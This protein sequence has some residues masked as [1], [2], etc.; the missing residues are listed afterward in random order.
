MSRRVTIAVTL[1]LIAICGLALVPGVQATDVT[2]TDRPDDV[3][4][5][6]E[7]NDGEQITKETEMTVENND[8][9]NSADVDITSTP[10]GVSVDASP[11][12]IGPGET[13]EVD[14]DVTADY[15]AN[16]GTVEGTVGD[17]AFE[18]EVDVTQP[19]QPG[20]EDEPLDLGDVL[21]GETESGDVTVEEIGGDQRLNGVSWE[22]DSDDSDGDLSFSGMSGFDGVEGHEGEAEWT[23]T[24][25]DDADQHED[26]EWTVELHDDDHDYATREVDVEARVIYPGQFGEMDHSGDIVFDEPR[27]ETTT[28]TQDIAL[29]IPNEGDLELDVSS[30]TAS[31]SEPGIS[32]SVFNSPTEIDGRSSET[33]TLRVEADTDLE[34]GQ[35]DIS[36]TASA[37]DFDV[38]DE[39]YTGS[40]WIEHEI[41]LSFA[42]SSIDIGDVPIGEPESV[43]TELE[44]T[45][46]YDDV[47]NLEV[48][49]EDGPDSWMIFE[50]ASDS[51]GAGESEELV[52]DLEF[53][54]S[55]SQGTD[56]EWVYVADGFGVDSDSITV[57]ATPVPLDLDPIRADITAF[58]DAGETEA[59]IATDA[60]DVIDAMDEQ[61]RAG[62]AADD[63]ISRTLAFGDATSLYL[64]AFGDASA[65]IDAG[66]HDAAQT[67]LARAAVA[68]NMMVVYTEN[69]ESQDLQTA[70]EDV[71]EDAGGKL[72][73]MIDDQE[74]YYETQ[75]EEG[76]ESLREEATIQRELAQI[77]S[78]Q[79]D[80]ERAE[81]LDEAADEAFEAY[82]EAVADGES[83]RQRA[84]EAWEEMDD[85]LFVSVLGEPL[86]VNPAH[87]DAF[88]DGTA[89]VDEAYGNAVASLEAAGEANRAET[90]ANEHDQRMDTLETTRLSLFGAVG[91]YALVALGIV[92]RTARGMFWYVQDAREAVSGDFLM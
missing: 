74:D 51:L 20:F 65:Q 40:V 64:E 18:F 42:D 88:T 27:D 48:R 63:D 62:T 47:E 23:V 33:A 86:L 59:S 46:G 72:E 45:L 49:Q 67:D 38:E 80:E 39:S 87:Y 84:N 82:G 52:F 76:D 7:P 77:A 4:I 22:I 8:A 25:D 66:E 85:D 58:E 53:D 32:V 35:Y 70:G 16:D 17:E 24:V 3:D 78:L 21:V 12:I 83:E 26:L 91:F 6:F 43:S 5:E 44:E 79:G 2:I 56:Y 69:L 34:E 31:S 10:S 81:T 73:A 50:G 14:L 11:S 55:A 9:N 71:L 92:V 57:V 41:D 54:T 75:L 61:M 89:T 68:Y 13:D 30:V 90:I 1:A 36:A 28:I 29:E 19:P 60:I 37:E 15:D